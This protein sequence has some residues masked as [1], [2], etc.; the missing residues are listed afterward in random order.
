MMLKNLILKSNLTLSLEKNMD[1][2]TASKLS[3]SR[4]VVLKDKLALLERALINFMID[5]HTKKFGYI[6]ISLL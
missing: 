6:E 1:F 3:G 2:D 4:F 5:I